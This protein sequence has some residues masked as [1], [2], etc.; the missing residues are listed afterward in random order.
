[1]GLWKEHFHWRILLRWAVL[2][3]AIAAL[4]GI[5]A[6]LLVFDQFWGANVCFVIVAL[7]SLS[8]VTQLAILAS[9]PALQ[10]VLFTFLLFGV[11]GV[12]VV[13]TVRGVNNWKHR[14]DS[15][16]SAPVAVVTTPQTGRVEDIITN[17]LDARTVPFVWPAQW[18]PESSSW[19]FEVT[20]RGNKHAAQNVQVYARDNRLT[21]RSQEQVVSGITINPHPIGGEFPSGPADEGRRFRYHSSDP[22]DEDLTFLIV[23]TDGRFEQHLRVVLEKQTAG[24][25]WRFASVVW[26]SLTHEVLLGCGSPGI[27]VGKGR[28]LPHLEGWRGC[29]MFSGPHA[30]P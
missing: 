27:D 18:H 19:V 1:M 7:L 14:R 13:E 15:M 29:E 5:A 26:D 28:P 9:D 4:I 17:F 24:K 21:T 30:V 2:G 10:R 20:N 23:D 25:P 16:V 22:F 3:W 8:K 12:L 6:L 11:I